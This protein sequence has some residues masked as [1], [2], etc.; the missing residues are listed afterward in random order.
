MDSTFNFLLCSTVFSCTL[1]VQEVHYY[2][3]VEV[4]T[5]K[6]HPSVYFALLGKIDSP[7]CLQNFLFFWL[8]ILLKILLANFVKAYILFCMHI[9]SLSI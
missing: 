4:V 2:C 6:F 8:P 3:S 5:I 7:F 1:E 9:F